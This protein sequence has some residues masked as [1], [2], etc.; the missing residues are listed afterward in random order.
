MPKKRFRGSTGCSK[1]LVT[2]L[3]LLMCSYLSKR[4]GFYLQT[5]GNGRKN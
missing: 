4:K 5:K 3:I 1:P 2:Y